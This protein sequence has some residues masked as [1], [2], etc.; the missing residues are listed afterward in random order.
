MTQMESGGGP[1]HETNAAISSPRR[2]ACRCPDARVPLL[3]GCR[4]ARLCLGAS[5]AGS[6]QTQPF[7]IVIRHRARCKENRAY[8]RDS[9]VIFSDLTSGLVKSGLVKSSPGFFL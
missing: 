1:S 6:V 8:Y 3:L 9:V 7:V 4:D 5:L 2:N